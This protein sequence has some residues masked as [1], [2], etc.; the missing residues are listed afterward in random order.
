M[1]NIAGYYTYVSVL[2]ERFFFVPDIM[3][4][5]TEFMVICFLLFVIYTREILEPNAFEVKMAI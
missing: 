5:G 2:D 4:R 1:L 3:V